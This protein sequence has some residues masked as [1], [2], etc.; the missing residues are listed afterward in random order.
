MVGAR[1][2]HIRVALGLYW[3]NG[4][5][6]GNYYI[7]GCIYRGY[8]QKNRIRLIVDVP[9][10][11]SMDHRADRIRAMMGIIGPAGMLGLQTKV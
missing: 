9:I 4:K 1:S 11:A 7:I 6:N 2:L 10:W 5:E 3:D 8:V